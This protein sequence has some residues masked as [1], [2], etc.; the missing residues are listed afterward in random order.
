MRTAHALR[1]RGWLSSGLLL[2]ALLAPSVT[3][4]SY[5]MGDRWPAAAD[6]YTYIPI[7]FLVSGD[8][9]PEEDARQRALIRESL[10][11]THGRWMK[12]RFTG[13]D[14]CPGLTTPNN[15]LALLLTNFGGSHSGGA[16]DV[17]DQRYHVG[18]RGYFGPNTPTFGWIQLDG[19][20]DIRARAV[21]SHE[22]GHGLAL[23]HEQ[24]RPDAEGFCA[25]GDDVLP[26]KVLINSPYDDTSVMNYCWPSYGHLSL[27]DI[28]GLQSIYGTSA[29]GRWLKALPVLSHVPLL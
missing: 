15:V 14:T 25:D 16:G 3:L 13:F 19:I 1:P 2:A 10:A 24:S 26:G 11:A 29:E 6:G 20:S 4:A 21:I 27:G 9:T 7:C 12:I 17:P 22:I 23:E 28:R 8:F 18:K 5:R